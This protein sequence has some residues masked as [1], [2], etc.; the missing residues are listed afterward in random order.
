MLSKLIKYDFKWINKVMTIYFIILFILAITTRFVETFEMTTMVTII[1]KILSGAFI[2]CIFSI[3]VTCLM[4]IWVKFNLSTYKDE[5]YLT[6]TLPIKREK[7]FDSKVLS[8][9]C[10]IILSLIVILICIGIVYLNDINIEYIKTM[11]N[12]FKEIYGS[13]IILLIIALVLIFILETILIMMSGI[14]GMVIGNMSNNNKVLKT[15]ISGLIS[16]I[17]T[18]ILILLIIYIIANFNPDLIELFTKSSPKDNAIP[19]LIYTTFII[20]L[21][22]NIVYYIVGRK[23]I[24]K[25]VNVD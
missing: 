22:F 8:G 4:R 12:S 21:V 16:Y 20:Y 23:L 9:I 13:S 14:L 5:S 6:H 24:K 11:F 7:V 15:V 3:L 2:G 25:G 1:D 17:I 10:C 18:Q 19:I